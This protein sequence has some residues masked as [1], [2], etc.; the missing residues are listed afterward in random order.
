MVW[1]ALA[2]AELLA[3]DGHRVR[4]DR[5]P[6]DAAARP[7]NDR[8]Q[9]YVERITAWSSTRGGRSAGS[10][11]TS[12]PGVRECFDWLDAPVGASTPPTC[13]CHTRETSSKP[14]CRVPRT[15]PPPSG[16]PWR[17]R[18]SR[19]SDLLMPKLSDTMEEG[20][21]L[22][23]SFPTAAVVTRGQPIV[24]IETDKA[25]MT[26]EAPENGAL[27]IVAP[28]G[29]CSRSAHRSPGSATDSGAPDH[30]AAWERPLPRQSTS[31]DQY[32]GRRRRHPGPRSESAR[33]RRRRHRR[34]ASRHQLPGARAPGW[35]PDHRLAAGA[36]DR[37]GCGI[38]LAG[39]HGTGPGGRIVRADVEPLPAARPRRGPGGGAAARPRRRPRPRRDSRRPGVRPAHPRDPTAA[40]DRPP[41]ARI[42][43]CGAPFR[44][45]ARHR[46][47]RAARRATPAGR[48][49][50]R[51]AHAHGDRP[52]RAGT[53]A[54]RGRTAG[55]PRPLGQR[56]VRRSR[57][58]S[59]SVWPS[60][61]IA[62]CWS[63]SS[64]T[65]T[66]KSVTQIAR[67]HAT[68]PRDAAT[69]VSPRPSSRAAPSRSA[70]LGMS[71]I[72]RFTAVIN[73][74]EAAILAVGAAR[75][76]ARGPRR[77]GRRPR[78][79]DLHALGGPPQPVR[80][81]SGDIPRPRS[82][83]WS[84]C[85]TAWWRPDAAARAGVCWSA[86]P[87]STT[88][89]PGDCSGTRGGS[90][91]GAI[92]DVLWLVEH[93]PVYTVGRHGTRADLFLSR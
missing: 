51:S 92:P 37:P 49:P 73:P 28:E 3:A 70:T 57:R 26:V 74:P 29:A 54:G 27:R 4:S 78:H 48:R 76:A 7:G 71:G 88:R 53:G 79:D 40:H 85:R 39:V 83:N 64:A 32:P 23:G 31:H 8:R 52:D 93:P 68:W 82:P 46:R 14:P 15:W 56:R 13:R 55:R 45:S 86:P 63:P 6:N 5:P 16:R 61:S 19:V 24:E 38:D 11:Q 41:D 33:P 21:V 42:G 50:P 77:T 1:I 91:R 72:D 17:G 80:R 62:G 36:P 30:A 43:H 58:R 84:R 18:R 44:A 65:P 67:R 20:T 12:P 81:R 47:V 25:D 22:D 2:A 35:P 34:A 59:T 69:G 60:P 75:A 9:R 87:G 90:V 89:M 66:T 10:R